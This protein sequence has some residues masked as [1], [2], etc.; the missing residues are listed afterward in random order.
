V[1]YTLLCV[2]NWLKESFNISGWR[3]LTLVMVLKH[4]KVL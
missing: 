2:E 1:L 3:G 4:E